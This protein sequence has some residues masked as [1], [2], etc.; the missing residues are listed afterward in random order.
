MPYQ[1][2][3]EE[4]PFCLLLYYLSL[5]NHWS[6]KDENWKKVWQSFDKRFKS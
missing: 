1:Q 4:R 5:I 3:M 6:G 2:C